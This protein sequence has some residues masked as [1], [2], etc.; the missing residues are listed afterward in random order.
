M[1][2]EDIANKSIGKPTN[3]AYELNY[4]GKIFFIMGKYKGD[5]N[6][7]LEIE[8]NNAISLRYRAEILHDEKYKESL[9]DLEKLLKIKPNDTW[10]VET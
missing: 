1:T 2:N 3:N 7:L 6:K 9:A 4:Q 8:L 5:L 10:V